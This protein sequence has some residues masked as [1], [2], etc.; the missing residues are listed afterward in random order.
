MGLKTISAELSEFADSLRF[1][2]IPL[3][4]L[5]SIKNHLLDSLGVALA[6]SQH[7]TAKICYQTMVASAGRKEATV[8]GRKKKLP[9]AA[10]AL[11]NGA[12]LHSIELDDGCAGSAVH[13]GAVILPAT[14]AAAESVGKGGKNFILAALIG[15]EITLRVAMAMFP[16]HRRMGF[17][18]TGTC[19]TFGAAAAAGKILQLSAPE[20]VNALG[21]AGTFASGVREGKGDALMMKRLHAGKAA[22]NGIL[23]ALLAK[24]GFKAPETIFDGPNGFFRIFSK[25]HDRSKIS[26]GLGTNYVM[27][28]CYYKPY[29][30]CRHFHAP[31]D[32][33]LDLLK[34]HTIPPD[35]VK[36][37][38]IRIYK[39]ATYY[40]E[41]EP[42][43][44]LDAQ[45]SLPYTLSVVFHEKQAL[46]EQFTEKKIRDPR[47]RNLAKKVKIEFDAA[48]DQEYVNQKKYAHILEIHC[49]DGRILTSR[50]DYPKGS[51][52]N[53]FTDKEVE[54]KFKNLA[55]LAIRPN[56]IK[57]VLSLWQ[58]FESV[59]NLNDL[60]SLLHP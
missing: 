15:Y 14:L 6:G 51:T 8:L 26:E 29:A 44:I 40:T 32:S 28:Q 50:V 16:H 53:P 52:K 38:A 21:L 41:T 20:M 1:E 59:Q 2:D 49:R 9:A 39:E 3:L 48:L 47:I 42:Q 33:L 37:I 27:E 55:A 57:A 54:D 10:A 5:K 60:G 43:N 34:N 45:F 13:P 4:T 25:E 56:Q 36:H 12:A 30:C 19:G 22:Q 18:P 11:I 58:R 31:I 7:E 35:Q 23:A 46:L 24:N 17:H